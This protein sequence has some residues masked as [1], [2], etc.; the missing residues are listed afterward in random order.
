MPFLRH[1]MAVATQQG[2]AF[3]AW[4]LPNSQIR[5]VV[6]D[7]D[8]SGQLQPPDLENRGAGFV[9]APFVDNGLAWFVRAD[10]HWQWQYA[11][12]LISSHF[13]EPKAGL[14][15][16][17]RETFVQAL[18][19]ALPKQGSIHRH[20]HLPHT[21]FTTD[22]ARLST[23][24]AHYE[25]AVADGVAAIQAGKFQKV[26]LAKRKAV[27]LDPGFD[28]AQCFDRLC[29]TYPTA[30]VSLVSLPGIGTWVGASPEKLVMMDAQGIFRT[31]AL[32]GTQVKGNITDLDEVLW[33]QK[34]IEE[35]ALVSRYIINCFK[36][37]RVREYEEMGPRT[38]EAGNVLH[39]STEFSVDTRAINFPQLGSVMLDLLHPTSAVCGMPKDVTQEFILQ[40]EGY[41]RQLYSGYLG[42]VNINDETAIFVNLRCMQLLH[43]H[44]LLYAGAGVT[45]GSL[46]EREWN[47]T[48]LK[49]QT[50]L[51]GLAG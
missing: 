13:A 19:G 49:L 27:A 5:N 35:Q 43:G 1:L 10:Y 26:V 6:V 47:E 21:D 38:V 36:K 20:Y 44:A 46:P 28:L 12:Q 32:A 14:L 7:L 29:Q 8:G 16:P 3:A 50:M 45:K 31:M 39:L 24:P 4:Q 42:P 48:E 40:H 34:E 22:L 15:H 2:R 37:V 11:K 17:N 9:A 41:D 30:F 25:Q 51:R 18:D 23:T 33:R